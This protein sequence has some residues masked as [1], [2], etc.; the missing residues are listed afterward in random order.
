MEKIKK[1]ISSRFSHIH[2]IRIIMLQQLYKITVNNY[3]KANFAG[4]NIL[5]N[6]LYYY[7]IFNFIFI[8]SLL[9]SYITLDIIRF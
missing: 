9:L 4:K 8:Y 3:D 5:E 6:S 7:E 1:A 2:I